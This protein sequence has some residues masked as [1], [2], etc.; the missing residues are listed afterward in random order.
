TVSATLGADFIDM[1]VKAALIG[2]ILIMLFMIVYYRLPG[3]LASLSLIFYGVIS[4]LM[5]WQ[6]SF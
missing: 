5:L 4:L 2:I 1:S 3:F 6:L